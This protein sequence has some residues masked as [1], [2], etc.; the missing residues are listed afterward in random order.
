MNR[1]SR[2]LAMA[3]LLGA[4]LAASPASGVQ[5]APP[6][7]AV[8]YVAGEAA[9]IPWRFAG[10]KAPSGIRRGGKSHK[11][12]RGRSQMARKAQRRA[13]KKWR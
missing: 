11:A 10:G 9:G 13:H 7:A 3:A 1:P 6:P 12:N 4:A 2:S 8:A 5:L